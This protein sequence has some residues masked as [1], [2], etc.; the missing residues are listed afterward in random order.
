MQYPLTEKIGNPDLFVGREMEFALMN[1]WLSMIPHRMSK[2]RVILAR[3]K[4]GK[5]VFIQRIFNQLWSDPKLEVIPFFF[6]IAETKIW[7]PDFATDYYCAFAS[8][9]ISF[10]ERNEQ[11]VTRPLE[12]EEIREYGLANSNKHLVGD[13]DSL[14][15]NKERG[16]HDSMWKIASSAPHRFA[17][18]FDK[19]FLVILDEFQNIT[20]Y[21]YRDE[22]CEGQ[23][24]ETL[25]GSFHSLSESKVAPMLVTGSYVGWLLQII[26]KY[27]EAGRLKHVHFSPYLSEQAGLQ[28]VYKYA[29]YWQ[30]PIT[31]ETAVM[32]NQLCQSDPFFISCV[33]QNELPNKDLTT[34]DGVVEVVNYEISARHSEMSKT[35][36]EYL[37]LTLSQVNDKYAKMLLLHLNKYSDTYWTPKQL[38]QTLKIDLGLE[39]IQHRLITLSEAD[40][41]ERGVADIEFRGLQ[42]G[43]L[44]LILRNRFSKEIE[45]FEPL[46]DLKSEF[47]AQIE[48]LRAENQKLRGMLNNLSGKMAE[49]QLATAFRSRKHFALTLFFKEVKDITPL[50]IINV[51]ERV[52]FQREDGKGMEIDIVAESKCGRAVLVE[53]KKTQ[54]KMGLKAVSAFQEK[55][56]IYQQLFSISLILPA[57]LSLGGFTEEALQFCQTLGIATACR[58]EQF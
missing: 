52:I 5:T 6:D 7:Y 15:K 33:I 17:A 4:S 12:L 38:K 2:S 16:F 51:R 3:R 57:F 29:H 50:N 23:P 39:Q 26:G 27:L 56:D 48:K 47:S 37:Q 35:W 28:A 53:V 44:C 14:L 8:Q 40:V 11:L 19:R 45:E 43:T 49:Y 1:K 31:N 30:E 42:D 21:V 18:L 22:K 36:N 25:A 20:Q 10:L 41:I 32:I 58:I 9:Y 34:P 24:N 46:S 54:T 13:V 55:V